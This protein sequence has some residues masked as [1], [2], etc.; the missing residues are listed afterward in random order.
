MTAQHP[1][2]V[3]RTVNTLTLSDE[4][5]YISQ[6]CPWPVVKESANLAAVS[7]GINPDPHGHQGPRLAS[8]H[9]GNKRAWFSL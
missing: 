4:L 6:V 1:A 7:S 8:D 5:Y 3:L 9:L 2:L